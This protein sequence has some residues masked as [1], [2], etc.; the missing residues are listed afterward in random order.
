MTF[1]RRLA[2]LVL[3]AGLIGLIEGIVAAPAGVHAQATPSLTVFA[4]ADLGPAFQKIV[5]Q[6]E[7][8]AHAKV[9]LVLGSTGTLAQQI[10]NGA[11]ADVFFAANESFVEGLVPDGL[12]LAQT[13]TR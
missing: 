12:V 5:P 6:F 7:K 2:G 1:T 13:R 3:A 11:P 9:T 10:R 4:A 8:N